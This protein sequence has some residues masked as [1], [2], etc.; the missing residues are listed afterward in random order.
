MSW[1]M[2]S[3]KWPVLIVFLVFTV[4][5]FNYFA[6]HRPAMAALSG[7]PRNETVGWAV[8]HHWSV[9]PRTI[10]VDLRRIGADAAMLDVDRGLFQIANR[11]RGREYDKVI[12]AF[13]GEQKYMLEGSYFRRLGQEYDWQ[14]P[15]VL[16][17]ELPEHTYN[18]D[19]S[20]AFQVWTGGLLGVVTAQMEDHEAMH[21]QWYLDDAWEL[22]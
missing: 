14:N 9:A 12:L 4:F 11:L 19:G 3:L 1:M 13:R 6:V 10:V 17:R 15:I 5:G 20:P 21:R 18:L 16:V 7:D 8:Y 2:R 22:Q